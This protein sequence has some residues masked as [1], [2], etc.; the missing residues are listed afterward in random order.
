MMK[1]ICL[2]CWLEKYEL[3]W[4][5]LKHWIEEFFN[6]FG[7]GLWNWLTYG[8]KHTLLTVVVI[9]LCICGVKW[10]TEQMGRWWDRQ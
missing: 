1:D 10:L 9:I 7:T 5:N 6:Q 3:W 8:G 4:E 2:F